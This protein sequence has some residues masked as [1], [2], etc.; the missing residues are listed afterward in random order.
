MWNQV[1][2][3]KALE[4]GGCQISKCQ[5]QLCW[6]SCLTRWTHANIDITNNEKVVKLLNPI[7]TK[8]I[9]CEIKILKN[10]WG[11]PN[12]TSLAGIVKDSVSRSPLQFLN[13][14]ITQTSSN[15][16]T[17]NRQWYLVY[18]YEILKAPEY[19]HSIGQYFMG[20]EA[21]SCHDWSWA[22]KAMANRL[23]IG[24]VLPSC[25]RI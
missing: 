23:W 18:V 21:P 5:I 14:W 12:I 3:T 7:K 9:K 2:P 6:P 11:D 16:T 10:L 17:V 15:C 19:C 8:K 1:L 20:S 25:S 13:T 24:W 4:P 22:Q